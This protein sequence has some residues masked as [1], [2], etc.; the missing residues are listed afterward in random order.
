MNRTHIVL[1]AAMAALGANLL[2]LP[3]MAEQA[4]AKP[5]A[6]N[7]WLHLSEVVPAAKRR[8]PVAAS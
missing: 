3:A 5:H 7:T 1:T 8:P 2:S 4:I 6:A